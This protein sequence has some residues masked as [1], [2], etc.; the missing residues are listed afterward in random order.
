[1]QPEMGKD[2][3][4]GIY[5]MKRNIECAEYEMLTCNIKD[6]SSTLFVCLLAGWLAAIL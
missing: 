6:Y 3:C 1:M 4:V 5:Y 2:V